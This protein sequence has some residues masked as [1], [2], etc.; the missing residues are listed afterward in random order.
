[1]RTVVICSGITC[2]PN[3]A[4]FQRARYLASRYKVWF[5]CRSNIC[6]EVARLAEG[7]Q[8]CPKK[9]GFSKLFFSLWAWWTVRRLRTKYGLNLVYTTNYDHA[10]IAGYLLKRAGMKWV[11][12]LWDTPTLGVD[13][14]RQRLTFKRLI[15]HQFHRLL[16]ALVKRV[17][18]KA[19][20]LIIGLHPEVLSYLGVT[21]PTDKVLFVT[22]GIDLNITQPKENVAPSK[23]FTLI[24]V[25]S[26]QRARGVDVILRAAA[27]L[28]REVKEFKLWLVGP[29]VEE[30]RALFEDLC[31]DNGLV[32]HVNI[33]G[34]LPH[35][36]V[37]RLID[38]SDVCLC[39][40]SPT[41]PNYHYAY[42]IK[43]FEYMA[44]G[45][46]VVCTRLR[47]TA[48]IIKDGE[49]GILVPP[50]DP[51]ALAQAV[52]RLYKDENLRHELGE[53]A[54]Q[55]AQK[56]DWQ[57]INQRIG[58]RLEQLLQEGGR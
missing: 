32:P 54:R 55:E 5:L 4:Q 17:L 45:K 57:R 47:G 41:I 25:G 28:A 10:L 27:L 18:S 22:N 11:V 58:E 39:T 37:L 48:Q 8:L 20:L 31:R 26:V 46:P 42:P 2:G 34:S 13:L 35:S 21:P 56:Y 53:K 51:E 36:E 52:L 40:L 29:V 30:E 12:D 3:R 24:Y 7:V 14:G 6:E 1:M 44:M 19:D 9:W 15:A 43:L 38:K 50:D 16:F 49:T 33:T 23:V